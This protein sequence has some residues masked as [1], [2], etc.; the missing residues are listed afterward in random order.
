[1]LRIRKEYKRFEKIGMRT[2]CNF[3]CINIVNANEAVKK[4]DRLGVHV[5]N[6]SSFG[7]S[8]KIRVSIKAPKENDRL[9]DA[10]KKADI[11]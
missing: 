8:N 6:C 1:M 7:L 11:L 5:R 10:I 3:G 2:D 9:F 4:L